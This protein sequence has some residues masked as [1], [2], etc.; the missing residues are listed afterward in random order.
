MSPLT[1]FS[2]QPYLVVLLLS[3]LSKSAH[4]GLET[5]REVLKAT[6]PVGLPRGLTLVRAF[7]LPSP[8]IFIWNV[9]ATTH[10]C[11]STRRVKLNQTLG[12]EFLL[13]T[14]HLELRNV[15]P[16][17]LFPSLPLPR[18]AVLSWARFWPPKASGKQRLCP[19]MT[20]PQRAS[21]CAP[22]P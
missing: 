1:W 17:F 15:P 7:N 2:Y 12:A 8:Y 11:S 18:I 16:S 5:W 6:W 22:N 9:A 10:T 3:S 19:Q 20:P 4:L 21:Q 13:I 14:W